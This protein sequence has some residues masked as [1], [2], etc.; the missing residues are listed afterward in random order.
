[1]TSRKHHQ[2]PDTRP[3][4]Y[5]TSTIGVRQRAT[6]VTGMHRVARASEAS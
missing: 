3:V 4:V 1:M 5:T 6:R 2:K